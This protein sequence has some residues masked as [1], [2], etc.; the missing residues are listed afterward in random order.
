MD[1]LARIPEH[2]NWWDIGLALTAILLGWVLSRFARRG[3]RALAQRTPGITRPVAVLAARVAQYTVM[4]VG[5]GVGLAFL[6]ANVQPLIAV[7]VVVGAVVVLVLRGIA[8]NFAAGVLLQTRK[9][10]SVGDEIQVAGPDGPIT[11]TIDEL[12]G[13]AVVLSTPDGRRVHI[14]NAALLR[15]ALVNDSVHGARRGEVYVRVRRAGR[16]PD[17]ILA[18]LV[19]AIVSAEGVHAREHPR[20][21]AVEV[22]PERIAARLQF[23]H[24]PLHARPVTAAVVIAVAAALDEAGETGVVTSEPPEPPLTPPDAV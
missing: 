1:A 10:V 12:N 18:P 3:V 5:L 19:D 16:A 20:A 7:V 22:S 21:L 24:H 8:D 11:G 2:L 17:E 23:W 9:P 14:P 4:L 6:G 15:E 13:R